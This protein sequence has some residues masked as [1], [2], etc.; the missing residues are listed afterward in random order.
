MPS[1]S[2]RPTSKL[3]SPCLADCRSSQ[4]SRGDLTGAQIAGAQLSGANLIGARLIQANLSGAALAGAD[5]SGATVDD[6][7]LSQA[8]DLTQSQLDVAEGGAQ[9]QLPAGLE[10]PA[11]WRIA[12]PPPTLPGPPE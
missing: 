3:P 12:A 11:S 4:V 7:D 10:R 6:A 5:L 8:R 1:P 9:T 2:R